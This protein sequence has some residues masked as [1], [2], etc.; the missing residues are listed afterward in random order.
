MNEPRKMAAPYTLMKLA[1]VED[2]AAKFG[3]DEYQESRFATGDL[4]AEQTGLS[5]HRVKAG[6][7]QGFA[8]THAEAEEV[9]VVLGGSGRVK[10]DDEIVEIEALDA[11]RVAPGVTRQFEAGPDGVELLAVGPRR[12]DDRGEILRDWW[13]D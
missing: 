9:Y 6:K 13:T 12:D 2:S 7:R 8:H 5:Y 1:D 10:L 3:F 11:I 4:G